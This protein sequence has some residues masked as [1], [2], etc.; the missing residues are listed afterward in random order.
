MDRDIADV[1]EEDVQ[2][3]VEPDAVPGPTEVV[4]KRAEVYRFELTESEW[5]QIIDETPIEEALARLPSL[6]LADV[7]TLFGLRAMLRLINANGSF[8]IETYNAKYVKPLNQILS[9]L[10]INPVSEVEAGLA[11][12]SQE[13]VL[14]VDEEKRDQALSNARTIGLA[15]D[16]ARAAGYS[17]SPEVQRILSDYRADSFELYMRLRLQG[18]RPRVGRYNDKVGK[19]NKILSDIPGFEER[20][21]PLATTEAGQASAQVQ[22]EAGQDAPA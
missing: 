22:P 12:A 15:L 1:R 9:S 3:P 21:R 14:K 8:G 19:I 11:Q 2:R 4:E 20:V 5:A 18:S 7:P 10:K 17:L 16:F 6:E 13:L